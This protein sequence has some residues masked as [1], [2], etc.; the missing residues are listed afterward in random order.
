MGCKIP[1]RDE[2]RRGKI[3]PSAKINDDRS[4]ARGSNSVEGGCFQLPLS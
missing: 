3:G 4:R 2:R 1:S